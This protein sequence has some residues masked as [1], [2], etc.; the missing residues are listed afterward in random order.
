MRQCHFSGP[1]L[2]LT[3]QFRW[4]SLIAAAQ[5]LMGNSAGI[6]A[7]EPAAR[8]AADLVL[9]GGK[10]RTGDK[11]HP[12]AEALAT[13]RDRILLVGTDAENC[14]LA[15]PEARKQVF[16]RQLGLR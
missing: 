6:R 7:A 8:I 5:C 12:E 15:G 1:T 10:I 13:G 16:F 11:S 14:A 9:I 3:Q 2:M 4:I